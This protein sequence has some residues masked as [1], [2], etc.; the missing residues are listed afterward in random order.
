[1]GVQEVRW[2]KG[3]TARAG[4]YTFLWK[5]N[6]NLQLGTGFLYTRVK[7]IQ[8]VGDRASYIMLSDRRCN[9]F[10]NVRTPTEEKRDGSKD[11]F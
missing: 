1:V 6:E 5:R 11:R 9:I 3:G 7:I 8:F 4:D 2:D 10:L